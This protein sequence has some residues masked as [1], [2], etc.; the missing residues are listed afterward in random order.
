MEVIDEPFD[1]AAATVSEGSLHRFP[2][3]PSAGTFLHGLLEW[4]GEEGFARVAEDA[5]LRADTLARRANRR[6]WEGQIAA[7][8]QWLP[9]LLT[10]PLPVPDSNDGE[11]APLRLDALDGYRVELEFWFA[12][13]RVNTRRL[14]ALVSAHTLGGRPRPALEPDTLNG[15]LKGFIDLVVEHEGRFYVLDWKS[16]HLGAD[17]AAYTEAAMGEAVLEKRYDVQYCLYLLAL[18]R[19]L[20]ARLPDYDI[21]RHLGGALYVFLRGTRAPSRGVHAERP[22]SELILALDALFRA[23]EEAT[24]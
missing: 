18:H 6:G 17:D 8:E 3:G 7:L 5:E 22:P 20:A 24:A 13:H 11:A 21:E 14:D 4:A 9:E 19:L 12:A 2:R 10:T 15:M 23:A 16:N 1:A